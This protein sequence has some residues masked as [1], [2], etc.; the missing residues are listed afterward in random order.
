MIGLGYPPGTLGSFQL[1]RGAE[2]NYVTV[3]GGGT[4][5]HSRHFRAKMPTISHGAHPLLPNSSYRGEPGSRRTAP[6]LTI[7]L[8]NLNI[9]G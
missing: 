6:S 7:C 3:V 8:Q 1:T 2:A 4:E 9:V 5:I